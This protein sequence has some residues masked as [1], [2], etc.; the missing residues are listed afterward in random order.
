MLKQKQ[1]GA[2]SSTASSVEEG[3]HELYAIATNIAGNSSAPSEPVPFTVETVRPV[4]PRITSPRSGDE[5]DLSS[6]EKAKKPG[7]ITVS[8]TAKPGITISLSVNKK[9]QKVKVNPKGL[10]TTQVRVVTGDYNIY[11]V[12]EDGHTSEIVRFSVIPKR[13]KAPQKPAAASQ[14]GLIAGTAQEGSVIT[15]YMDG[16]E[17]GKAIADAAGTWHYT[18]PPGQLIPLGRHRIQIV[19]A[20]RSGKVMSLME[21]QTTV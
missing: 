14:K 5:I 6:L 15:L 2:S 18:P 10:W 12:T 20:D 17:L 7:I 8:G 13:E 21:R 9:M 1:D 11:A 19:V 4:T 3:A 16:N